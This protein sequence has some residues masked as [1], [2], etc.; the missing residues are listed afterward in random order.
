[1]QQRGCKTLY[2]LYRE[3]CRECAGVFATIKKNILHK[4][5]PQVFFS[6]LVGVRFLISIVYWMNV[7]FQLGL[8]RC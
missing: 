8:P 3:K 6:M 2:E 4:G 5:G 7:F 1:M